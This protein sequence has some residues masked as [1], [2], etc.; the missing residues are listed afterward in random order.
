MMADSDEAS[1]ETS[2]QTRRYTLRTNVDRHVVHRLVDDEGKLLIIDADNIDFHNSPE[3]L[4]KIVN[5]VN[6]ELHGLFEV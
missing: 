3:D 4:G 6:G 5:A 1:D 2:Q